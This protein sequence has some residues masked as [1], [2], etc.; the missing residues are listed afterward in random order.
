MIKKGGVLNMETMY[1]VEDTKWISGAICH[2][3]GSNKKCLLEETLLSVLSYDK[4]IENILVKDLQEQPSDVKLPA[5]A[6][7]EIDGKGYLYECFFDSK[8]SQYT[9]TRVVYIEDLRL[10]FKK[11]LIIKHSKCELKKTS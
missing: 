11:N 1:F 5:Y 6:Y 8:K 3:R 10:K 4:T 7:Y 9:T 2:L